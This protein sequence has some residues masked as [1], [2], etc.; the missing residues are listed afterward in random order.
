[1]AWR[2]YVLAFLITAAIF[3]TA[4]YAAWRFNQARVADIA[5]TEQ[6]IAIDILSSET[7]FEELGTLDCKTIEENGVLSDELN[8]LASRLSV[9]EENLGSKDPQVVTLK[10][11]Y[12]LLEI[13]DYLLLQ[14]VS[15]KC[16]TKP[17][18]ILYFYSNAGDCAQCSAAGDV[19]TYLRQTYP[20][21]RVYSFD[22][23][24]DLSALRTLKSLNKLEGALP[25][26]IVNNQKPVYGF[27]SLAQLQALI[28]NLKSLASSTPQAASASGGY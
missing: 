20:E 19:L 13:K 4:F 6:R 2:K 5:A 23:N 17:V 22:Y 7:Q 27:Q 18:Y 25:A 1:M 26:Y 8:T 11:Q 10:E 9:A 12:S 28:P 24:I 15:Q 16:H 3:G 21:L 14:Q